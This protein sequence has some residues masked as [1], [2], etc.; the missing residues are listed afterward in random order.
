MDQARGAGKRV[1]YIDFQLFDQTA[2]AHSDLFLQQFCALLTRRLGLVDQVAAYWA[3]PLSTIQRCSVYLEEYILPEVHGA[4]VLALDEVDRVFDTPV[5]SDFFGML[6]AWHNDRAVVPAWGAVDLALVTSTEPYQ[7]IENLNQSPFNVGETLELHDFTP[8]QV[9]DLNQRHDHVLDTQAE[10]DLLALLH[11][12]PYLTHLAL[13]RVATGLTTISDLFATAHAERGPFGDHLR[14]HL[15]R[16]QDR[17]E[18]IAGLGA[19][20]HQTTALA[21]AIFFR[22]RGAGL[23]MGDRHAPQMR[24]PLYADYFHRQLAL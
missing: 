13:Y 23:V 18:L 7:F 17:P 15:F 9:A 16:I 2:L 6:R 3:L 1:V 14:Y 19:V 22:L 8:A 4:L 20:L 12:H 11:G 5:R 10:A 24:C 21:P